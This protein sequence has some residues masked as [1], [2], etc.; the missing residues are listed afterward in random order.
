MS[1]TCSKI[2]SLLL[3]NEADKSGSWNTCDDGNAM[4][5]NWR[6]GNSQTSLYH[7]FFTLVIDVYLATQLSSIV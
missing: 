7:Y 2:E 4:V 5:V 3:L 6:D 1:L